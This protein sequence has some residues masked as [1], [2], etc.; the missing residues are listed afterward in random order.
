MR[1]VSAI[2]PSCNASVQVDA[3]S[4]STICNYCNSV[5][6]IEEAIN[7]VELSGKVE[8]ANS[9][10]CLN[11]IKLGT[12]NYEM[13][14]FK[15]AEK[16]FHEALLLEPDNLKALFM[17]SAS[18]TLYCKGMSNMDNMH[19]TLMMVLRI[20]SEQ[21]VT[22][23]AIINGFI[24]DTI[25][26]FY[27]LIRY[28]ASFFSGPNTRLYGITNFYTNMNKL[29]N[30]LSIYESKL[31]EPDKDML[32]YLYNTII[33]TYKCI[34]NDWTY[35]DNYNI[36]GIYRLSYSD[37]QQAINYLNSYCMRYNQLSSSNM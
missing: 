18:K 12:R 36:P 3:D 5:I 33:Y 26:I 22:D 8:I 1:L 25:K 34:I 10:T 28:D 31:I 35:I 17:E 37:K 20:A 16:N 21:N 19:Q 32:L 4:K 11:Y 9:P 6:M 2:C 15:E 24:F 7:K 23:K 14:E 29:L 30:Y 27:T 13:C